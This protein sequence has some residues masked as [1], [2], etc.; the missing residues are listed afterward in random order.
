MP[1]RP[2]GAPLLGPTCRMTLSGWLKLGALDLALELSWVAGHKPKSFL[3]QVRTLEE[4]GE[5]VWRGCSAGVRVAPL[6]PH[7]EPWGTLTAHPGVPVVVGCPTHC[8]KLKS[9]VVTQPRASG[10]RRCLLVSEE[11]PG[12]G[13]GTAKSVT[14]SSVSR[15]S[16][17]TWTGKQILQESSQSPTARVSPSPP[18]RNA[19]RAQQMPLL[20]APE[21]PRAP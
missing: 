19:N 18:P 21:V 13:T 12:G 1:R 14:L 11:F 4:K 7:T 3:P 20:L 10:T 15:G 17:F 5:A 8:L 16:R 2:S 6:S 9:G